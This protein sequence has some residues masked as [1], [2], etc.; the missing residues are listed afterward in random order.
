LRKK[1]GNFCS[2]T[3]PANLFARTRNDLAQPPRNFHFGLVFFHMFT[4]IVAM[5]IALKTLGY[6]YSLALCT[7]ALGNTPDSASNPYQGIV[8][9]NVFGLRPPPPP[10]SNE[11]IKPPPPAVSLTGISTI[12][13]RKL[14]FM[15]VQL[16]PKPGEPAKPGPQFLTLGVGEREGEIEVIDIDEK[17]GIVKL[18]DYGV[19][20]NVPF[21]KLP[22]TPSAPVNT[23]AI[24]GI[25]HPTV[26]GPGGV[27][28]QRTIPGL[29]RTVR[30][31]YSNLPGGDNSGATQPG[32]PGFSRATTSTTAQQAMPPMSAEEDAILT[33]A[34]RELY[35]GDE[36]IPPLPPTPITSPEDL[37]KI[38]A[39]GA[40][41]PKGWNQPTAPQLPQ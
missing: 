37:N 15:S 21:A 9:R 29:P 19:I 18:N 20:T 6:A 25:P 1:I 35:R 7:I 23:A 17:G 40:R 2:F 28:P 27:L 31:Q 41:L 16:P 33:E 36:R 10:P 5:K 38:M 8:D 30:T 39:P 26:A 14:A 24:P 11:P 3:G 12:L 34:H 32:L 13:G 4:I 22:N